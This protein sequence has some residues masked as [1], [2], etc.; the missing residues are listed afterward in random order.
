MEAPDIGILIKFFG[1]VRGTPF[2]K[3]VPRIF[4][5]ILREPKEAG[6]YVASHALVLHFAP[7]GAAIKQGD[8][9]V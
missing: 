1:E 9:L 5:A 3:R 6:H 4:G 8:Y 7:G 2:S